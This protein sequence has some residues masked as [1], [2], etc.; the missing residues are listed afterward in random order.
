MI[1]RIR[2]PLLT[3]HYSPRRTSRALRALPIRV[4]ALVFAFCAGL[5]AADVE[6]LKN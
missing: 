3:T 6:E 5:Q 4:A 1:S 2:V